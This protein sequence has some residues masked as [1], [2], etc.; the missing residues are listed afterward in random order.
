[1]A[2]IARLVEEKRAECDLLEGGDIR[3]CFKT[4][5]KFLLADRGIKR[6]A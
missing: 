6:L 1:M 4:G 5:E 2:W 3:L